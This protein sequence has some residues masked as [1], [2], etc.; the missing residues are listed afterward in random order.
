MWTDRGFKVFSTDKDQ[1]NQLQPSN[2]QLMFLVDSGST[3]DLI[4]IYMKAKVNE[5]SYRVL[6]D[7]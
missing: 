5:I 4:S 7:R 1:N 6:A 2:N 3:T